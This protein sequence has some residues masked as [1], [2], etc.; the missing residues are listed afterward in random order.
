MAIDKKLIA[1]GHP[2]LAARM[3]CLYCGA[4]LTISDWEHI[5][6]CPASLFR[7]FGRIEL[8]EAVDRAIASALL[9]EAVTGPQVAPGAAAEPPE[10]SNRPLPAA[11]PVAGKDV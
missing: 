11:E 1:A 8:R 7:S 4:D 10:V 3:P 9:K 2:P 6:Y 5:V